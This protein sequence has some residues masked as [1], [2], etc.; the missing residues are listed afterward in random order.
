MRWRSALSLAVALA[1]GACGGDPPL[2]V[3]CVQTTEAG[4]LRALRA[5]PGAVRLANDTRISVCLRRVRSGGDLETMSAALHRAAERL[6]VRAPGNRSAALQL[7]YLTA[8]VA[9]G[10]QRSNGVAAELERRIEQ[11]AARVARRSRA[12]SAA[13]RRGQA[14]GTASG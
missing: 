9:A 6:A 5:A 12:L 11:P 4:Y 3:A 10:A 8:A 13:V 7:G 1:I 14:A 2:P